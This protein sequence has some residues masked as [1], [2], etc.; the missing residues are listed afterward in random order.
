MFVMG[1]EA[2]FWLQAL[3]EDQKDDV[4]ESGDIACPA[5]APD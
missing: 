3:H 2:V 4:Q 1:L 5:S